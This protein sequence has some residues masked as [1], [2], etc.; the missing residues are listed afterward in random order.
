VG[1]GNKRGGKHTVSEVLHM[2]LSLL[3]PTGM[4]APGFFLFKK[5]RRR[6]D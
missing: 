6:G 2:M 3:P 5:R 1:R 4:V